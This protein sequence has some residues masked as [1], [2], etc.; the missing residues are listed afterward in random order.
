M[1]A[2]SEKTTKRVVGVL[3]AIY[4]EPGESYDGR[5]T[6]HVKTALRG[7]EIELTPSEEHR[8]EENGAL[9]PVGFTPEDAERLAA[10]RMDAYR[11]VRGDPDAQ[12][13]HTQRQ[14][15][16][17]RGADDGGIVNVDAPIED[18]TVDELA[19]WIKASKPSV[20]DTVALAEGAPELAQKVLD[21][22]TAAQGGEP[23]KGVAEQLAR[24]TS[25][26]GG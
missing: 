11:A 23:R 4:F 1:A 21:A 3:S 26:T 24:L 10:E 25:G 14:I 22:E 9:L 16:A 12:Q 8:L 15:D 13:R 18:G 5:E 19:A 2:T 7:D 17:A 6:T 20:D